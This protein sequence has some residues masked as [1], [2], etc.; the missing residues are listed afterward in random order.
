MGLAGAIVAGSA[1]GYY[2][3]KLP[4]GTYTSIK[5][6]SGNSPPTDDAQ[7][8]QLPSLSS[9]PPHKKGSIYFRS[10][11]LQLMVDDGTSYFTLPERQ[12]FSKGGAILQPSP[13]TVV[14]WRA[15]FAC[16]VMAVRGYQDV[17]TGS[18][19][20]AYD[21][22]KNLLSTDITISAAGEWQDGGNLALTAVSTGD[23]IA[24]QVVSVSGTPNYLVVQVDLS[25]P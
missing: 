3:L 13:Q 19:V 20:T 21:G 16:T 5:I 17:G 12:L 4:D 8:H 22:S 24:I 11:L 7:G 14:V 6:G 18:V 15:P 9:D 25:Q 23:S 2:V 10:D 1:A